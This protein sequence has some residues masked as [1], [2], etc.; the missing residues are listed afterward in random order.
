MALTLIRPELDVWKP[1]EHNGTFRGFSLAFVT[2]AESMRVYWSDDELEKSTRTKGERLASGLEQIVIAYPE[3]RLATRGRGLA[4]GLRTASGEMASQIR[5]AAF[6]RGLLVETCGPEDE[7]VKLMPP[8][9]VASAD[10][11][12]A[13]EILN[14]SVKSVLARQAQAG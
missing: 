11:D 14:L 7:V 2:G 8:L 5:A 4:R 6:E 9:T 13:L 3:A 1:A 12:L 10:V